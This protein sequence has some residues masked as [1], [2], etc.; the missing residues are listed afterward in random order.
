MAALR[1]D[2]PFL[3]LIR[4]RTSGLILFM[5]RVMDPRAE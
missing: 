4:E 2:R 3:F 5:G 1:A